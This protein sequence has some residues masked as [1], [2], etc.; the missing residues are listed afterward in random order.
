MVPTPI[1]ALSHGDRRKVHF[2]KSCE[3]LVTFSDHMEHSA[4]V[5]LDDPEL[6]Q[7]DSHNHGLEHFL[8]GDIVGDVFT[9]ECFGSLASVPC[10]IPVNGVSHGFL[11][12]PPGIPIEKGIGLLTIQLQ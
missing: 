12:V 5:S 3:V 9:G 4:M 8:R 7:V 6:G 2:A 10:A 11:K 1:L